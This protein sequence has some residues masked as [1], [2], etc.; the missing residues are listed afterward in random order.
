MKISLE[1]LSDFL[2]DL[3]NGDAV[4]KAAGDALTSGG[5][6]VE[7]ID[8]VGSDR[9]IDVEVTSNRSD[10]LSHRGVARELS[11]LMDQRLV[12]RAPVLSECGAPAASK[13]SVRIDVTTLCPHYTARVVRG[14]K[15]APSPAW[16][17]RRLEAIGQ[18]SVNNVVDITNYV[19]FELGQPLHAFDFDRIS[20]GQII[21]RQAAAGETLVSLDGHERKLQ[22]HMLVIADARV[23]VALAGVMGGRDSEVSEGTVNILLESARFDPLCVR[24]TSRQLALKSESSYRYERGIDP[25]LAERASRRAVELI[26]QLAGG[27]AMAGVVEAG[28]DGHST[29][30][31][32][33]RRSRLT[34]VLGTELSDHEI[35][36]ALARLGFSPE[37]TADGWSTTVPSHRLD[38]SLEIDLIEEVARLVGY[39]RIGVRDEIAIHLTPPSPSVRI[40]DGIRQTLVAGGYSEA[41]TFSFVSDALADDFK[42]ADA[43]SLPRAEPAVRKAD[44]QL[45]PSLLP[46]LLEAVVRNESA[47]VRDARLFEI[48]S[49]FW[50]DEKQHLIERRHLGLAG[51]DLRDVR[52]CVETVLDRL[53]PSATLRLIP[54]P[55]AGLASSGRLEWNGTAI[56]WIGLV[57]K[58]TAHKLALREVP[59]VAELEL[60]P[61]IAGAR[62][63]PQLKPLPRFPAVQRDVSLIFPEQT[64][65]AALEQV[66]AE[67]KLPHLEAL[68]YVT[69]YRGK[70][71]EKGSKSVTIALVF[72]SA[73][74]T[75]VSEEID[76][77]IKRL[78]DA[79]T[80]RLG[81]SVRV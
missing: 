31:V 62:L 11:A 69:T 26:L 45:R 20:G 8:A 49:V 14:V 65:Y 10:C 56:G 29:R 71:L 17:V 34:S 75:L 54:A 37:S 18:R 39:D 12:D 51:G 76:L 9:V 24:K 44:A 60:S 48:G 13:V 28:A 7:V 46:A 4:A 73:T 68:Q 32:Q 81:A 58:A 70:P 35:S 43:R 21:V 15:I 36:A 38:V 5:L 66:V 30:R 50:N 67:L 80:Q 22:P 55:R 78:I 42:P 72:R 27:E 6:P 52:G 16:L 47:G 77:A 57:A 63:V 40:I 41:V 3:G 61:L 79:A 33:L 23:P 74:G 19:M 25:L 53:D 2:P 59:A 64:R 1:W